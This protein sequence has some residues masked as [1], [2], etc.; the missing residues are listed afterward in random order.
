MLPAALAQSF[1]ADGLLFTGR[2]LIRGWSINETGGTD[3]GAAILYD[4]ASSGNT[5]KPIAYP[6]TAKSTATTVGPWTSGL[7]VERGCYV[8]LTLTGTLVVFYNTE[9]RV[10]DQFGVFS[11][12]THDITALGL[13]RLLDHLE[14]A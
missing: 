10:G 7:A 2:G 13:I 3:P 5:A 8:D 4:A 14:R 9:T 11:D 12:G 1:T 6:S